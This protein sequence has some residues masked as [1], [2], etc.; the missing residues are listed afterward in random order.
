MTIGPRLFHGI[1]TCIIPFFAFRYNLLWKRMN[2]CTRPEKRCFFMR[3]VSTVGGFDSSTNR[4]FASARCHA[5][6][7]YSTSRKQYWISIL[8]RLFQDLLRFLN[9]G[10]QSIIIRAS[11]GRITSIAAGVRI[12]KVMKPIIGIRKLITLPTK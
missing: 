6:R 11:I 12:R 4:A 10:I 5:M 8:T 1:A 9:K 7:K 3:G 2:V